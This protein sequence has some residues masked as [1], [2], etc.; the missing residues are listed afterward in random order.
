MNTHVVAY[1]MLLLYSPGGIYEI[2]R[3][4]YVTSVLSWGYL[5][6]KEKV[7]LRHNPEEN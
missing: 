1:F 6:N 4:F 2:K 3:K 5:R 7:D